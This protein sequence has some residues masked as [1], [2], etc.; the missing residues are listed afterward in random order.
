MRAGSLSDSRTVAILKKYFIPVMVTELCTKD[1]LP[2]EDVALVEKYDKQL[3]AERRGSLHGGVAE[4]MFLPDGTLYQFYA[5]LYT[6]D[7]NAGYLRGESMQ[8]EDRPETNQYVKAGR[9]HKKGPV[10]MFFRAAS[11]TLKKV[12][13]KRPD[14]WKDILAGKAPE[15]AEV[16]KQALA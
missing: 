14:D 12:H 13:G 6:P 5:C 3:R 9:E 4:G 15:V 7:W 8:P 11:R 1:L 2:K 16:D 10:R